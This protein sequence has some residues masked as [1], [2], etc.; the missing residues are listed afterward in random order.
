LRNLLV[1]LF[2]GKF[3]L[4]FGGSEHHDPHWR[5]QEL[6]SRNLISLHAEPPRRFAPPLL[7]KEGN[8]DIWGYP[9][10]RL[11]ERFTQVI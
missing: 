2:L 1:I 5:G 7:E 4:Q 6:S 9:R 8:F 10:A 3:A 11:Y